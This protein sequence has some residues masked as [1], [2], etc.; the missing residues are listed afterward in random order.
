MSPQHE[1]WESRVSNTMSKWRPSAIVLATVGASPPTPTPFSPLLPT[2]A[3]TM[4]RPTVHYHPW[5]V[6]FVLHQ[7][8]LHATLSLG[9]HF[10]KY[11]NLNLLVLLNGSMVIKHL[12]GVQV[13]LCCGWFAGCQPKNNEDGHPKRFNMTEPEQKGFHGQL[14]AMYVTAN[15]LILLTLLMTCTKLITCIGNYCMCPKQLPP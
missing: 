12:F 3:A 15:N 14:C 10:R 13:R 2:H 1:S 9:G 5:L 6:W 4:L 11:R 8:A 7:F